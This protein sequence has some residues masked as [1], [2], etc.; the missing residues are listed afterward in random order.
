MFFHMSRAHFHSLSSRDWVVT[1]DLLYDVAKVPLRPNICDFY[2]LATFSPRGG[3]KEI[4]TRG[5]RV[6]AEGICA[7]V[8]EERQHRKRG[9][10]PSVAL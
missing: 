10:V 8:M 5:L 3:Q 1:R 6:H 7:S 9:H 4:H 2:T